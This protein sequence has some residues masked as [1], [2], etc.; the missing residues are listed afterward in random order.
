M[1]IQL[2]IIYLQIRTIS[3]ISS[4]AKEKLSFSRDL[5]GRIPL[6][7]AKSPFQIPGFRKQVIFQ[8]FLMID[9]KT[10]FKRT[11]RLLNKQTNKQ[12]NK[13]E[14]D[15]RTGFLVDVTITVDDIRTAVYALSYLFSFLIYII[16]CV[17]IIIF[18]FIFF[19]IKFLKALS[20]TEKRCC[21][22][23][24]SDVFKP[25]KFYNF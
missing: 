6:E 25:L 23:G 24:R 7:N 11:M 10:S 12:T 21:D 8:C 17:M 22:T 19:S 20:H 16:I 4:L 1:K 5:E 15:N 14:M 13:K 18:Y 9:M 2:T 3:I